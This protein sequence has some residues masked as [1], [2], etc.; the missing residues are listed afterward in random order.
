MR[1]SWLRRNRLTRALPQFPYRGAGGLSAFGPPKT[2]ACISLVKLPSGGPG[3]SNARP[4]AFAGRSKLLSHAPG[5]YRCLY[6]RVSYPAP[7]RHDALGSGPIRRISPGTTGRK[8]KENNVTRYTER[9]AYLVGPDAALCG[10][11]PAARFH[12]FPI[13][14]SLLCGPEQLGGSRQKPS[15]AVGD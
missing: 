3:L 13:C 7:L 6:E 8:S 9:R 4:A 2:K 10:S 15:P 11:H 1:R 5:Y 14:R 12:L